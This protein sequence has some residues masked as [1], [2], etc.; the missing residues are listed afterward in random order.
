MP[1]KFLLVCDT[2]PT[3][4]WE[5]DRLPAIRQALS[6]WQYHIIDLFAFDSLE[7]AHHI[8]RTKSHASFFSGGN[9]RDLNRKF[10]RNVTK[11]GCDILV[12]G[13]VDCYSWFLL[14]ETVDQLRKE[15]IFVVGILGDDEYM[16]HRN[17][18]HVPMFNKTVA[19]V[20]RCVD[21]YSELAP[22]T[23]Y[24]LP[25]SC[26]FP[27]EEFE[28]LQMED[29]EKAH[30]VVLLGAPFGNRPDLIRSLIHAGVR[31][32]LFHPRWE[33]YPDL[34]PYYRGYL[35]SAEIDATVR[36]S[37][38]VLALLEDHLTG[39]LHMNTKIW[40]AVR[41]GQFPIATYYP[42]LMEDYGFTENEDVVMYHSAED[43]AQKVIHYLAR[44]EERRRIAGNLFQKTRKRFGYRDLYSSLF[45]S[46]AA[47]FSSAKETDR[48]RT[49]AAESTITIVDDSGVLRSHPGFKVIRVTKGRKDSKKLKT[50]I[51]HRISTPYVIYTRGGYLY[52]AY[53][54]RLVGLFPDEFLGGRAAFLAVQSRFKD[55][56]L[57]TA[58]INQVVWR[59]GDFLEYADNHPVTID[60]VRV[61]IP[62]YSFANL[63]LCTAENGSAE[64]DGGTYEGHCA[65]DGKRKWIHTQAEERL[66]PSREA[67]AVVGSD[68]GKEHEFHRRGV[69]VD[70]G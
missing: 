12:L 33:D 13:T 17:R 3:N 7:E 57:T 38:I 69:C 20:K 47:E 35:D 54:N 36:K 41:M 14:P 21:L 59:R 32:S 44:P 4:P 8:H 28:K 15:G 61:E 30:D 68:R 55:K 56:D 10:Y 62:R 29:D 45:R 53:L 16:F 70:G 48:I 2:L 27:E 65:N 43:L 6:E 39:A 11:F 66:S 51:L 37:K 25:N 49:E 40:E 64:C 58:D 9:L 52:S 18:L 67:H 50:D 34:K 22:D 60:S 5:R 63:R 1:L 23:C 24:W 19:Y 26:M 31:V 42:P 46:L